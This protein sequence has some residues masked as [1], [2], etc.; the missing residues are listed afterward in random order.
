VFVFR[1]DVM[2]RGAF[3]FRR[4]ITC[5]P[6]TSYDLS[7][8][9]TTV[10]TCPDLSAA[11]NCSHASH[12][13][14]F[15]LLQLSPLDSHALSSI[16]SVCDVGPISSRVP[17]PARSLHGKLRSSVG[18][19]TVAARAELSLA[20]LRLSSYDTACV[21]RV[22]RLLAGS[23][24]GRW[25]TAVLATDLR[26]DTLVA[27][28][29]A[30]NVNTGAWISVC[31]PDLEAVHSDARQH[32]WPLS[33]AV[34]GSCVVSFG[35]HPFRSIALASRKRDVALTSTGVTVSDDSLSCG[36]RTSLKCI[37]MI[38]MGNL[39][40]HLA[41]C[42]FSLAFASRASKTSAWEWLLLARCAEQCHHLPVAIDAYRSVHGWCCARFR[43]STASG[44]SS[45]VG[46]YH[47]RAALLLTDSDR[48]HNRI[49]LLTEV[50]S[51]AP[52]KAACDAVSSKG[53]VETEPQSKPSKSSLLTLECQ[54][55]LSE[56]VIWQ[57]Q[58]SSAA[59]FAFMMVCFSG[60]LLK[61]FENL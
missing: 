41:L 17:D 40:S 7:P 4:L 52:S 56:S 22:A 55:P 36:V 34:G 57:L 48:I 1:R 15:P 2:F 14:L 10:F 46:L 35:G 31:G 3:A 47:S 51:T 38:A 9:W 58:V 23:V 59:F 19:W 54:V 42:S 24:D 26:W 20:L 39:L 27:F 18:C 21:T 6:I 43:K 8:G 5:K 11:T 45:V 25:S 44:L 49:Q 37:G 50:I 61:Q 13:S 32:S 53:A 12:L 28:I 29:L 60:Q 33:V 30:V 16:L